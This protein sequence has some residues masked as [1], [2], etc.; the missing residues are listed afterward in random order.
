VYYKLHEGWTPDT[1][2]I[3]DL[4]EWIKTLMCTNAGSKE[5][6]QR[7]REELGLDRR[8]GD[9]PRVQEPEAPHMTIAE[10]IKLAGLEEVPQ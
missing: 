3:T 4:I 6:A 10:Y 9:P 1:H 2:K 5:E 8:P 7:A